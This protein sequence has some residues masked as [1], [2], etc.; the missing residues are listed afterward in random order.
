MAQESDAVRSVA[1]KDK[2]GCVDDDK[3]NLSMRMC[4]VMSR[5]LRFWFDFT[6]HM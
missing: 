6:V 1:T 2:K 3:I 4:T 5:V